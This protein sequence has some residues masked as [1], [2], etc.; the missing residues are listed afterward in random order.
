[1][2]W[3]YKNIGWYRK[4]INLILDKNTIEELSP[5]CNDFIDVLMRY[6][7]KNL[8]VKY[9]AL[10]IMSK[11][12]KEQNKELLKYLDSN[13]VSTWVVLKQKITDILVFN[14]LFLIQ[15][16]YRR[17][18][19]ILIGKSELQRVRKIFHKYWIQ[20]YNGKEKTNIEDMYIE[21]MYC[22][23]FNLQ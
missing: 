7:D 9:L 6:Y 12:Y 15:P 14:K 17:T 5:H 18:I 19:C 4:L 22:R 20:K 8:C 10:M 21:E 2:I 13:R 23:K 11:S 16:L 3:L 1:M